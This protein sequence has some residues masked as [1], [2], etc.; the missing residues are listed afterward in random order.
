VNDFG[1]G[2]GVRQLP[3]TPSTVI[4]SLIRALFSHRKQQQGAILVSSDVTNESA[5]SIVV[6]LD[7]YNGT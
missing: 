3:S 1:V 7:R 2:A 5:F 6:V 4:T